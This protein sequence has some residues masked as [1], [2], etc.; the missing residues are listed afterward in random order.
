MYFIGKNE[1]LTIWEDA[2]PDSRKVKLDDLNVPPLFLFSYPSS[3]LRCPLSFLSWCFLPFS[4]LSALPFASANST[5]TVIS[6]RSVQ[7]LK[8]SNV[9]DQIAI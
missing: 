9:L 7:L 3:S 1:K 4:P 6:P 8:I 2:M 5:K